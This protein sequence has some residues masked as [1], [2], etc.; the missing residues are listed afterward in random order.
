MLD[1]RSKDQ[2]QQLLSQHQVIIVD[3]Y[4]DWCHP[5]K[6]MAPEF[7]KLAVLYSQQ[8]PNV[9]F[10]KSDAENKV[11]QVKGLPTIEFYVNG[12]SY[13]TI[14]GADLEELRKTLHTLFPQTKLSNDNQAT[15][16]GFKKKSSGG[17]YK[18]YG[19][20]S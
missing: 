8:N 3:I 19:S 13:H 20:Y 7:E 14:L 5:C 11:F 2:F 18:T 15:N 12:Q 9:L 4:A 6:V 1:I 10:C 16:V 17:Q